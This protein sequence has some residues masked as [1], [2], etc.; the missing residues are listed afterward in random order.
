MEPCKLYCQITSWLVIHVLGISEPFIEYLKLEAW[1]IYRDI[2]IAKMPK[3]K[4]LCAPVTVT[5]HS[6]SLAAA[7]SM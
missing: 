1:G 4:Y 6:S 5:H 7:C 3:W 2:G